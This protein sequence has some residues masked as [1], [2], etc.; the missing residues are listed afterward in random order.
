MEPGA[1]S[2]REL[3]R[4]FWAATIATAGLLALGALPARAQA[5]LVQAITTYP[6]YWSDQQIVDLADQHPDKYLIMRGG[7]LYPVGHPF[8]SNADCVA[9]PDSVGCRIASARA[10]AASQSVTMDKLC[11][12]ARN[13][14]VR[15][16]TGYGLDVING[17]PFDNNWLLE[18]PGADL[19]ARMQLWRNDFVFLSYV[20]YDWVHN[21][22]A[23]C[24]NDGPTPSCGPADKCV[25][26]YGTGDDVGQQ[27]VHEAHGV[28]LRHD[29]YRQWNAERQVALVQD[30]GADC[31]LI[32]T[33]PGLWSSYSGPDPGRECWQPTGNAIEGPAKD[34]DPCAKIGGLL[35]ANPYGAAEYEDASNDYFRKL[36]AEL[37]AAGLT[38]VEIMTSDRPPALNMAWSWVA[39][40]VA[41]NPHLIG[42][43]R[44][45][46]PNPN[47]D[48]P[49]SIV[50]Y[51]L[52][53]PPDGTPGHEVDL[54]GDVRGSATGTID[55][56]FWCDC[57]AS[58]KDLAAAQAA[59][60]TSPGQYTAVLAS[61]DDPLLVVD[62]CQYSSTGTYIVKVIAE[63]EGVADE[64][65]FAL[66][67]DPGPPLPIPAL[68]PLM[69]GTLVV[70]I[71][72]F[73]L[74]ALRA[75]W[76]RP[77]E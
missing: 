7:P 39:P 36:F 4:P 23:S 6:T 31:I 32:T 3:R 37:D 44:G 19:D 51:L 73:A 40:D 74:A 21:H 75:P 46:N 5:P 48:P 34:F 8:L 9:T 57:A 65:R 30:T 35:T 70:A 53:P 68:S 18:L 2:G 11:I 77:V 76:R 38:D 56:H 52:P 66:N 42:E 27:F 69:L 17:V 47:P 10:L 58:T 43:F 33:K 60:G 24:C 50:V 54:G 14:I 22:E 45:F 12:T 41:A 20:D 29:A 59:C 1:S 55:Y 49:P 15:K 71:A 67:V 25:M 16:Y 72:G 28:D 61:N 26:R 63:R 64:D 62:A 13:E